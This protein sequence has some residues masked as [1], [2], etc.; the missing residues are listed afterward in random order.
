M[1]ERQQEDQ[2]EN[3]MIQQH[4]KAVGRPDQVDQMLLHQMAHVD[5]SLALGIFKV[6]QAVF[7]VVA[8]TSLVP[9]VDSQVV[10]D[11]TW[12]QEGPGVGDQCLDHILAC[13]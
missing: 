4:M 10:L 9:Q 2:M 1:K 12:A 5:H 8:L 13:Q 3:Q 11:H 7:L 6:D